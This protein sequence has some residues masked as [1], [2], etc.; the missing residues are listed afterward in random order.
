M[1]LLSLNMALRPQEVKAVECKCEPEYHLMNANAGRVNAF[2]KKL[3]AFH[4]DILWFQELMDFPL[5][6]VMCGKLEQMGY[7][8]HENIDPRN[9]KNQGQ[10]TQNIAPSGLAI[11]V[12]DN[13]PFEILSGH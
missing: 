10:P 5:V 1:K 9:P 12:K 13:S 2:L 11:F 8:T 3:P 7:S 4:I 6:E